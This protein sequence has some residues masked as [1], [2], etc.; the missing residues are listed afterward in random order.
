M[1]PERGP[2][3]RCMTPRRA[4][5]AFQ[6][7][8]FEPLVEQS[9]TDIGSSRKR[10]SMPRRPRPR[11]RRPVRASSSRPRERLRQRIR[12]RRGVERLEQARE[13][14][15]AL[16]ERGPLRGIARAQLARSLRPLAAMSR[17]SSSRPPP[18][19][20]SPTDP[21]RWIVEPVALEVEVAH[22]RRRNP[23]RLERVFAGAAR[24]RTSV[25]S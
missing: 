8:A 19:A 15:H 23:A 16:A 5:H 25:T 11:T 13:R 21:A 4:E 24:S 1:P 22:D 2:C 7:V 12:R 10:S 14:V 9:A 3:A 6:R 17:A 18:A 20:R